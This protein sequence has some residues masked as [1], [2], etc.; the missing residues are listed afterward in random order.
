MDGSVAGV[1]LPDGVLEAV[2]DQRAKEFVVDDVR[3]SA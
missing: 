2:V 1:E 3:D